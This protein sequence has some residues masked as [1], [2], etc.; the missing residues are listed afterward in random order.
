MGEEANCH[1]SL[2]DEASGERS[3]DELNRSV[4][5]P[6]SSTASVTA[7][8]SAITAAKQLGRPVT[9]RAHILRESRVPCW[10]LAPDIVIVRILSFLGDQDRCHASLACKSWRRAFTNPALWRRRYFVFRSSDAFERVESY[11]KY[12]A[13]FGRHLQSMSVDLGYPLNIETINTTSVIAKAFEQ[14]VSSFNRTGIHLLKIRIVTAYFIY[15]HSSRSRGVVI[16]A[17]SNLLKKQSFLRSAD[18]SYFC[19]NR[20]EGSRLLYA[21]S[22]GTQR[23]PKEYLINVDMRHFFCSLTKVAT[24]DRYSRVMGQFQALATIKM[25]LGDL[26]ETIMDKLTRASSK[27]LRH[28]E[29]EFHGEELESGKHAI[30][31]ECWR[32]VS[33]RVPALRVKVCI[34]GHRGLRKYSNVL[35]RGLPLSEL[36]VTY[37]GKDPWL[38]TGVRSLIL[39]LAETFHTTLS[40]LYLQLNYFLD[41]SADTAMVDLVRNCVHLR[42]L[43]VASLALQANTVVLILDI[44]Q[45]RNATRTRLHLNVWG[46]TPDLDRS[47]RSM[48]SGGYPHITVLCSNS[49]WN[50]LV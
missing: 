17:L 49:F 22:Y 19:V 16:R 6:P 33:E 11:Q 39:H 46:M 30:S 38:L 23:H 25:D 18:L 40:K 35:V 27:T 12:L 9:R 42:E 13:E 10:Q 45:Y 21:L 4:M 2:W 48:A 29:L 5:P 37:L 28:I 24:F 50:Q 47:V 3:S 36:R 7:Q 32:A 15:W 43:H 31:P 41:V 34:H 8:S 26:N 20:E 1:C 14:F 44:I